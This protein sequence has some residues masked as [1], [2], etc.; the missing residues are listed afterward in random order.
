MQ[1]ISHFRKKACNIPIVY[2][3]SLSFVY[4]NT[5]CASFRYCKRKMKAASNFIG[6]RKS[7]N[8]KRK[9]SCA[10]LYSEFLWLDSYWVATLMK[11][12][13]NHELHIHF[14]VNEFL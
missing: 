13:G 4:V 2:F 7:K 9:T 5:R 3:I 10:L 6:S 1:Q 14:S 8:K 12:L 11:V